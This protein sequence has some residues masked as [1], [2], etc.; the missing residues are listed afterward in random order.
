VRDEVE[1]ILDR[2]EARD[3]LEP[4]PSS[5]RRWVKR[6]FHGMARDLLSADDDL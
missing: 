4:P 1:G 6:N 5:W 2:L 3:S